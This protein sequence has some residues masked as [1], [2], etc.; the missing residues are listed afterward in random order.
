ML[1]DPTQ[2]SKRRFRAQTLDGLYIL[3]PACP[4]PSLDIS[5]NVVTAL[6]LIVFNSFWS[7][8]S[9]SGPKSAGHDHDRDLQNGLY[10]PQ[11][12]DEDD[13]LRPVSG[14]TKLLGSLGLEA[15]PVKGI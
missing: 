7:L 2:I 11:R 5:L 15:S 10:I 3:L 9:S 8:W 4:K 1:E 12:A 14:E 13:E 6:Y